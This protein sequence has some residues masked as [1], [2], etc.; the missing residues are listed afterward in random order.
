MRYIVFLRYLFAGAL[1]FLY[2]AGFCTGSP[3]GFLETASLNEGGCKGW[4]YDADN[5]NDFVT[6]NFYA[7]NP[8]GTFVFIGSAIANQPYHSNND[9]TIPDNHGFVFTIPCPY[10]TISKKIHAFI[11]TGQGNTK[12]KLRN[13]PILIETVKKN[14]RY[15]DYLDVNTSKRILELDVYGNKSCE[16][17]PLIVMVHGGA[18]VFG[19]KS[20]YRV[21]APELADSG[22]IVAAVNYRLLGIPSQKNKHSVMCENGLINDLAWYWAA[23]DV[24]AAIKYLIY[25]KEFYGIDENRIF[26]YGESAGAI[27]VLQLAYATEAEMHASMGE[28]FFNFPFVGSLD[29]TTDSMFRKTTYAIAGVGSLAGGMMHPEY[30]KPNEKIPLVMLHNPGDVLVN[31]TVGES[32]FDKI[33][34]NKPCRHL[35][36]GSKYIADTFDGWENE[37]KGG[38]PYHKLYTITNNPTFGG[39]YPNCFPTH[40]VNEQEIRLFVKNIFLPFANAI[41]QHKPLAAAPSISPLPGVAQSTDTS[42]NTCAEYSNT[43]SYVYSLPKPVLKYAVDS[44]NSNINIEVQGYKKEE[45]TVAIYNEFKKEVFN[46]KFKKLYLPF[47]NQL[48]NIKKLPPGTYTVII[49]GD[50]YMDSATFSKN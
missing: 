50:N 28:A 9:A 24:N 46:K 18:F 15:S 27:T 22:Y 49:T 21:L 1:I 20:M 39:I 8:T 12:T 45:L 13:T 19:N 33:N 2:N 37:I 10:K 42:K 7:E 32:H 3:M 34:G 29:K 43:L 6:V 47:F 5:K 11:I 44:L 38:A 36:W 31:Y 48:V 30:L 40:G 23:Q 14:I 25:N 4:A 16:K 35:T 17:K 41:V 26:L